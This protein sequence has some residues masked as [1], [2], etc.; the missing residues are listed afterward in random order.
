M[1]WYYFVVNKFLGVVFMSCDLDGWMCVIDLVG[2]CYWFFMVG[3]LDKLSEGLIL[4]MN[5][6]ELVN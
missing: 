2:S 1:K 6:G 5:D 4:V 3:R